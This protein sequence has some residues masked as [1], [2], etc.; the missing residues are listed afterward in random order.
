MHQL[1]RLALGGDKVVPAPRDV[2]FFVEPENARA[3]GIA[4]MMVV[5]QPAVEAGVADSCLDRV[6][7]HER[8]DTQLRGSA[9][10][11]CYEMVM[12]TL[13]RAWHCSR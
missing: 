8:N 11:R 4:V 5:E 9:M 1:A 6:E 12:T 13:P 3:D 10:H 2:R 7:V